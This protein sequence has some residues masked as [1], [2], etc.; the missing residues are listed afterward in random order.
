M[1]GS[2]PILADIRRAVTAGHFDAHE[3]DGPSELEQ[4]PVEELLLRVAMMSPTQRREELARLGRVR[5]D[6]PP[7]ATLSHV[8]LTREPYAIDALR[9]AVGPS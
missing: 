4:I 5:T 3:A 2:D 1:N 6:G 9:S 8:R 7:D